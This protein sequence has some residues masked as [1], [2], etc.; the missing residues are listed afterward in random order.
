MINALF[1]SKDG[2]ARKFKTP[3]GIQF[4][5]QVIVDM[6]KRECQRSDDGVARIIPRLHEIKTHDSVSSGP[7]SRRATP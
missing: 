4:G 1:A 5:W 7:R 3:E 2:G 6:Y